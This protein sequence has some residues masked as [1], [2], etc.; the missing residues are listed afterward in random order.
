[1]HEYYYYD[2]TV[3][4]LGKMREECELRA[5]GDTYLKPTPSRLHFHKYDEKCNGK[6]ETYE[7]KESSA[8]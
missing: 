4:D 2:P 8:G 5:R 1:M 3:L 7:V 6:C